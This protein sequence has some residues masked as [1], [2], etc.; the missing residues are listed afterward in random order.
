VARVHI[1]GDEAGDLTFLPP[2]NGVSRYFLLATVTVQDCAV[3]D[4]LL[5]LRRDLAWQGIDLDCFHA[6]RDKPRIKYQVYEL[7]AQSNLRID[8]TILDKRKA[9]PRLAADQARFYKEATFLHFKYVVPRVST[10]DDDLHV[11]ASSLQ[12]GKK[13]NALHEGIGD[14]LRQ[15]AGARRFVTSFADNKTDP[16]L[17]LADYAAWAVQRLVER[18]E[19]KFFGL[20]EHLV[21]SRFEPFGHGPKLYY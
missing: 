14:V 10:R 11:V 16:C 1:F 21:A 19:D 15:V 5:A 7:M 8:A 18:G 20:I 6:V 17:Q 9:V 3:G 13:K 12:I 4:R 2:G